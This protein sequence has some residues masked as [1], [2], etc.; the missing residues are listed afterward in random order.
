MAT[1]AVALDISKA[2]DRVWHAGL[3]HKLKSYGM[4]S[5]ICGLISSFVSNRQLR[6]VLNGKSAQEY[7][8]NPGVPQCSILG[9]AVLVLYINDLPDDVVCDIANYADDTTV[10]SKCDQASDLWQQLELASELES[11]LRDTVD[12]G[13]KWLVDFNAGKTQL[14]L[15][16]RSNNICAIAVK[17]HESVL[18]EKSSFNMLELTFSPKLDLGSYIIFIAKT[19]S[20]KIGALIRS[21]KFFS[22]EVAQYLYKSTI[23]PCMGLLLSRLG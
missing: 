21:M 23:H 11:D 5:Q 17:M 20:K 6:V 4:S 9:P 16:D 12:W 19:A 15:F 2:F 18:E 22:P 8:V 3:L 13:R 10:Y 7:P 1:R 14:V